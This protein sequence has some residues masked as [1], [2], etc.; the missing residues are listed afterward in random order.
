VA[1][2]APQ[3]RLA[4]ETLASALSRPGHELRAVALPRAEC[5][6]RRASGD[7]ALLVDFVRVIGPRGPLTQL[8]LLSAENPELAKRPPRLTDFSPRAI[9]RGLSLGVVGELW[10][11]GAHAPAFRGLSGWQLGDSYRLPRQTAAP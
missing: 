2:D 4:A 8:A 6:R 9:A 11:E 1:D 7:F 3:L 10:V 5:A